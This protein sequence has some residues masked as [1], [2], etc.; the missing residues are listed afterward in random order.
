MFFILSFF[1]FCSFMYLRSV[2]KSN[3]RPR[4]PS[5]RSF[6]LWHWDPRTRD[7]CHTKQTSHRL[8]CLLFKGLGYFFGNLFVLFWDFFLFFACVFHWFSFIFL[9]C[10]LFSIVFP[11]FSL[12]FHWFYLFFH[13][14]ACISSL[15]HRFAS[16]R[17]VFIGLIAFSSFLCVF[18][19]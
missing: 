10:P 14:F 3:K 18:L 15:F 12:F 13:C 2:S 9:T 4:G 7:G 8:N 5:R 1:V 19:L 6:G 17:Y 16:F 11:W